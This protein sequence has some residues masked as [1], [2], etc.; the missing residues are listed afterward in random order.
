MLEIQERW[1]ELLI[2]IATYVLNVSQGAP[3]GRLVE[4]R[5]R[6]V[7]EAARVMRPDGRRV[8]LNEAKGKKSSD[9]VIKANFPAIREGDLPALVTAIAEAMT[10]GNAQGQVVGI[11]ERVGVG[12]LYEQFGVEDY[13]DILDD[14][15]PESG[16]DKY[17]PNRTKEPEPAPAP[18]AAPGAPPAEPP[19][20]AP[21]KAAERLL[22]A[23]EAARR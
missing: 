20:P 5:K 11:D 16:P 19:K 7:V 15:Y 23:V 9:I 13:G 6:R 21:V 10:L 2:T 1:R 4:S 14:Q 3:N 18:A 8:Y 17:D 12:L 22:A